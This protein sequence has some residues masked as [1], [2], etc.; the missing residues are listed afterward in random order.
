VASPFPGMDPYLE[1][2]AFWPDFHHRFIDDW[3]DAIANLLPATY[4]ARLNEGGWLVFEE[5]R[6][7]R[8][9]I[10]HRPNRKL[11]GVL[12]L[13]SPANKTGDGRL[14]YQNKLKSLLFQPVHL[15]VLDLL[16]GGSRFP[17]SQP[18][19]AGDYYAL[20]SRADE[21]PNCAVYAWT[22]R[23]PLPTIPIPLKAPD[24]DLHIDLSKVFPVTHQRGRYAPSLPYGKPPSAPLKLSDAQWAKALSKRKV[25]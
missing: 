20:V 13:L 1:D 5:I 22:V 23:Q 25:P 19:P 16:V 24:A 10:L 17:L 7:S 9:E 4:E 12:E 21:R 8:I 2:P 3:C 14:E 15:V 18:L 11:I 6:Q